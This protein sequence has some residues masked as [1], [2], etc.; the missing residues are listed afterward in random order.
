MIVYT[1]YHQLQLKE[2]IDVNIFILKNI[3]IN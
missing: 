3:K 2:F 1:V